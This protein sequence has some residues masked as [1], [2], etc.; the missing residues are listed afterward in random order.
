[1]LVSWPDAEALEMNTWV[2]VRGPVGV[3]TFAG[4]PIP[5]VA[6]VAL[7]GVEAPAQPYLY[8]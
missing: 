5:L 1:M 4:R 2:R 3:G 6:A 8:P 7:E